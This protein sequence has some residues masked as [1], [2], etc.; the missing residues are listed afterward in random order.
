MDGTP[1]RLVIDGMRESTA[2]RCSDI[3]Q[4]DL[5]IVRLEVRGMSLK[6]SLADHYSWIV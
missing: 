1:V 3:K 6:C 5:S 2:V 4:A